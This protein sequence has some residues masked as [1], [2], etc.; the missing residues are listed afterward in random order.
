M[1]QTKH[2]NHHHMFQSN[3]ETTAITWVGEVCA[4]GTYSTSETDSASRIC[5][6][7]HNCGFKDITFQIGV[8]TKTGIKTCGTR[9]GAGGP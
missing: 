5:I 6:V 8:E 3:Q 9:G 2:V 7:H 4:L 1:E